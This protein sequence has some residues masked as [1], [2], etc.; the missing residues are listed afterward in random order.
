MLMQTEY[1]S[2]IIREINMQSAESR[3]KNFPSPS[4]RRLHGCSRL[5]APGACGPRAGDEGNSITDTPLSLTRRFAAASPGGRGENCSRLLRAYLISGCLLISGIPCASTAQES[6]TAPSLADLE[7]DATA[8]EQR[9]Q[10][11]ED[12]AAIENL[13]RS[14]GFFFDKALWQE[15]ADLFTANGRIEIAGVGSFTGHERV[16][17]YLQSLGQEGPQ[18]GRL[19]DHI[20]LQPVV[21]VAEDGKTAKGRWHLLAQGGS[22]TPA[23]DPGLSMVATEDNKPVGYVG[24]GIYEND[25]VKEDGIWKISALRLFPRMTARDTEGWAKSAIP[26]SLP[27]TPLTPDEATTSTHEPYPGTSI[28]PVHYPHPAKN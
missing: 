16:L 1:P 10:R 18:H 2:M 15:A 23:D 13:Q 21:T 6:S 25:Y 9:L 12:I 14:Y 22:L 7:R 8:I 20:L 19:L 11:Q 5:A 24:S 3:L 27:A 28:P 17:A 26:Q 4:G